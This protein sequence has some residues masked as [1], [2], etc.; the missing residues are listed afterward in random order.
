MP[1]PQ[2]ICTR[3]TPPLIDEIDTFI[4]EHG[5]GPSAGLRR[6]V[7]EWLAL[8]RFPGLEFRSGPFGRRA[9]LRGGPEVWE[10]VSVWQ[11]LPGHA[12][13]IFRH[14]GWL[15]RDAILQALDFYQDF[16]QEVDEVLRLNERLV[17]RPPQ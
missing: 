17:Q 14:F 16:P 3:L 15:D 9:A 10:I 11:R 8:N 2:P 13:E 5:Y 4:Y 6:I 1:I 7:Q 12:D